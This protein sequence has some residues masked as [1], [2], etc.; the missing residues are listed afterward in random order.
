MI[1]DPTSTTQFQAFYALILSLHSHL[2]ENLL[3]TIFTIWSRNI[4]MILAF[5]SFFPFIMWV[6]TFSSLLPL[7][8]SLIVFPPLSYLH[9]LFFRIITIII[10]RSCFSPFQSFMFLSFPY[11]ES[12]AYHFPQYNHPLSQ[13]MRIENLIYTADASPRHFFGMRATLIIRLSTFTWIQ[14]LWSI[15]W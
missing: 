14:C 13:L 2:Y 1:Q 11:L 12:S 10:I 6:T 4:T 7:S 15:I 5:A 8:Q 3:F 9:V